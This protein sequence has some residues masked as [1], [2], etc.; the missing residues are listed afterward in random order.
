M[1]AGRPHS[2]FI[3]PTKGEARINGYAVA[4]HRVETGQWLAYILEQVRLY[5]NF[6]GLENLDYFSELAGK[7]CTRPGLPDY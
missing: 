4:E 7:H 2:R 5:R 1:R 3:L 6:T